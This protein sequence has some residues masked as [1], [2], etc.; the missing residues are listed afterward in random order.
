M[1]REKTVRL[2]YAIRI[3]TIFL[4]TLWSRTVRTYVRVKLIEKNSSP[5][6]V[7]FFFFFNDPATPEI[8]P[9]PLRAPLPICKEMLEGR[10]ARPLREKRPERLPLVQAERGDVDKADDVWS[11][12]AE[13]GDDLTAVGVS[14][15]DRRADRK[16]VV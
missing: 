11:V 10:R 3:S 5:V 7:F 12:C 16:S 6:T 4:P 8:S 9:L 15:D 13:R 14:D 1:A 2:L